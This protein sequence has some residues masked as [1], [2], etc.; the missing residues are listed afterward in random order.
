[1]KKNLMLGAG[2]GP[3]LAVLEQIKRSGKGLSVG[4][5]AAALGMSYMGVKAHC[6]ALSSSGHL[7]TW[8][9]PTTRGRPRLLYKL[10]DSGELLFAESGD[11]LA[12]G[13]LREAAGLWGSTA[14]QKLLAMFFR[15]QQADYAG[16]VKAETTLERARALARLRDREGRMSLLE[17]N[18]GG[19]AWAIRESHNPLASIMESYP[20]ARVLEEHLISEIVGV[21]VKRREEGRTVI[22]SPN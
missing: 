4:D 17:E 16:R 20:E 19:D 13:L 7:I 12:V 22:F 2:R 21:R 14:P 3:R 8:R 6:L 1:M 18:I 9:E 11:Q 5:I 15:S 10:A